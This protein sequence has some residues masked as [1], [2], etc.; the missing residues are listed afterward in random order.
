MTSNPSHAAA[1]APPGPAG[2]PGWQARLSARVQRG[3]R[4][5]RQPWPLWLAM[6]CLGSATAASPPRRGN[7]RFRPIDFKHLRGWGLLRLG[8]GL[9]WLALVR[10]P[11]ARAPAAPRRRPHPRWRRWRHAAQHGLRRALGFWS[12]PARW[13]A[14]RFDALHRVKK[15]IAAHA[16]LQS[17]S[18]R[19]GAG[20]LAIG[21][22]VVAVTTPLDTWEQA[23]LGLLLW[24]VALLIRRASGL[25]ISLLLIML[26]LYAS[27]R[28]LWWRI[29]YTLKW[30]DPLDLA[31][32]LLLLSAEAY[33]WLM[34]LLG[35]FQSARPLKREPVALPA[36]SRDWPCVDIYIPTYNEPMS[37]V[38]PTVVAALAL[39]WPRHK[40]SVYVLDDGRR[41]ECR[42]MAAE[43]GAHYLDRPDNRHAKAGNLNHA[44]GHTR[45]EFI[46]IF[47]CDHVPTGAF[48]HRV[49]GSFLQDA[50]LALVQ[51]PHH[52]FSPDP[53][54][55]NLNRFR[56][57]PN[58]GELFHGL[59]Q[60]GNDLWNATFFC[61]SCAVLRRSALLD[62][63]GFAVETVTEDA[64][65]A[66]RL[67]RR[68][69]K[70]ALINIALAA[71]L[72]TESLSAHIGQRIR[73]ARGMAQIFRLDNPF[74]GKGLSWA[75]RL[76]YGSAMLHFFN[77]VPRLIF[78]TAPTA[79][80][81]A[82][83]YV[84]H[85]APLDVLLYA[86]P[87]IVLAS[88]TNSRLQGAHR[89]SFWSEVYETVL[90]WYI[91]LP[92]LVALVAPRKGKFNVTIKGGG[93]Q[94]GFFDWQI[95]WPFLLLAGLN[96]LA[97]GFGLAR[98]V[99][100]PAQESGTTLLNMFWTVFNFI[101]I[102]AAIGVASEPL[103]RR[104][105]H[106][107]ALRVAAG[108][109]LGDGRRLQSSIQDVSAQGSAVRLAAGHALVSGDVLA[110][111][112]GRGRNA[113]AL[114]ACVTAATARG[115]RLRWVEPTALQQR[116]LVEC[117]LARH[118]A[119]AGWS[120]GRRPDR[121]MAALFEV[122]VVGLAGYRRLATHALRELVRRLSPLRRLLR[123]GPRRIDL[124]LPR[125]LDELFGLQGPTF[126]PP[127]S[128]GRAAAMNA[129]T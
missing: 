109:R 123:R 66:L 26:S 65:T 77:G 60:D 8:L 51:T 105:A 98:L 83:I 85:A 122:L 3:V 46:A 107:A 52:F 121:L 42:A 16:W 50:G 94:R 49:M 112:L 37:V 76:C 61:G 100:G 70:T 13:F 40:F 56:S 114:T 86:M 55:R 116:A 28:Y 73:W 21:A 119:W 125:S 23:L 118:D 35:Y 63:G 38:M 89:G 124:L 5:L 108:L 75:Q 34:L 1:P 41:P 6:L 7:T 12:S 15:G 81:L 17:R 4:D 110:L 59:I 120:Q 43:L 53:F 80:L 27:T 91:A 29:V 33:T 78:L 69:H 19:W 127:A 128:A 103:Q 62:I 25:S 47:D 18:A 115:L 64:H 48:L 2:S 87:P 95:A 45:G 104:L 11:V 10:P 32:G 30:D 71:G 68:G 101:L 58:E 24:A 111:T 79:F 22:A 67:Q 54:E 82:G 102:G 96:L 84:I 93:A 92:T 31:W 88:I 106:R 129:S 20:G 99:T 117:T 90:A 36:D 44:L 57:M 39:D 14:R 74:I 113:V 126:A 9:A 97:F 72:A